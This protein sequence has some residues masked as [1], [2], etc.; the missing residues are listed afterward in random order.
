[1][2]LLLQLNYALFQDI[3]GHAGSSPWLDSFMVFCANYLIFCLPLL[4][5][6]MWGRPVNWRG[7]PLSAGEQ[8]ILRERRAAVLWV[9]IACLAAYAMNLLIEQVIFEPRPFI[10]H[11][12]HQLIAHAADGS[13]PS[14]HTAWA[15]ALAGMF[16]LQL[17]PA[18]QRAR[19]QKSETGD[20]TRL[21]ALIY[22]GLI[23]L[24]AL[25]AGCVIGFA[26]VYAGIHYP[27]DI[28]GGAIDGLIAALVITLIRYA[29]SR[30]TNAL[31]RF[32]GTIHLA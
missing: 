18:W 26:R 11:H 27:G 23:T 6:L 8:E 24:L 20:S 14:D 31:L 1:M 16:L 17:L 28:L 7:E 5:L 21:K 30:P 10:S 25:L 9:A 29:L 32:A 4:M 15:F 12:V 22:P 19:R 3:N 13:F 2:S